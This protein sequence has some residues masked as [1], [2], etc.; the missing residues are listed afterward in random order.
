[1]QEYLEKNYNEELVES[2]EETIK[3]TLNALLEVVKT[4]YTTYAFPMSLTK[5]IFQR[6]QR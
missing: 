4:F 5:Y 1:M 6:G 3:L 2:E